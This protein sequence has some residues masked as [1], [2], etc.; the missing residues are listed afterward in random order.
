MRISTSKK[1]PSTQAL[2][3]I[4]KQEFSDYSF[5]LFGLGAEKSIIVQKSTFVGVQ[6]SKSGNDFT[7]E[8]SHPTLIAWLFSIVLF[9]DF[10]LY[11]GSERKR[12]KEEIGAFLSSRY[13]Q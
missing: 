12:L 11:Y 4:L 10:T 9:D 8:S 7:L 6:I 13:H 2:I 1:T 5:K 3:E